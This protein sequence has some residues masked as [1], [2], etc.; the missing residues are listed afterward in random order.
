MGKMFEKIDQK[1]M[2]KKLEQGLDMLKNKPEGELS[3]KLAGVN[4]EELLRKMNEIDPSKLKQM[5]INIEEIK[6]K[7]TSADLE[8]IKRLAG[9][10]SDAVMR[11]IN[12]LLGR[13]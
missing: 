9:K 4:R 13:T 3:K 5:N 11:K 7:I 6:Q 12:E 8:K 2:E 10:D 1:I